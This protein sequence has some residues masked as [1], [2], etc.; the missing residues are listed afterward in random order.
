MGLFHWA[1]SLTVHLRL[2]NHIEL[3]K[4]RW[5]TTGVSECLSDTSEQC[6]CAPFSTFSKNSRA[7]VREEMFVFSKYTKHFVNILLWDQDI[8]GNNTLKFQEPNLKIWHFVKFLCQAS[9]KVKIIAYQFSSQFFWL[10]CIQIW[11]MWFSLVS[12][13][14]F[15][16]IGS[17]VKHKAWNWGRGVQVWLVS[18]LPS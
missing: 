1:Q 7:S 11:R 14:S 15:S 10:I 12:S 16:Y 8:I 18:L 13:S 5:Y 9:L 4:Y 3:N 2:L 17:M 6:A